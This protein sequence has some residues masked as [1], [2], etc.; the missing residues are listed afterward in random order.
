MNFIKKL[1]NRQKNTVDNLTTS[2]APKDLPTLSNVY[3]SFREPKSRSLD[4]FG[5]AL[6]QYHLDI[7]KD[8]LNVKQIFNPSQKLT[9]QYECYIEENEEGEEE[10]VEKQFTIMT[11]N[12]EGFS[13]AECLY[14]IHNELA[15][16]LKDDDHVFFEGV[17][18]DGTCENGHPLFHVVLGS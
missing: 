11:E 7:S 17:S 2:L 14:H 10:D 3:W 16:P 15:E 13:I 9:I 6:K 8:L 12:P 1:F 18:P 4:E 5:L